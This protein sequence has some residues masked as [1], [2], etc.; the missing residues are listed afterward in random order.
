M[1]MF[2]SRRHALVS[3]AATG[4]PVGCGRHEGDAT[5][6]MMR[7]NSHLAAPIRISSSIRSGWR[8][9]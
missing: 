4:L 8:K 6:I 2:L 3:F 9:K 7:K 1:S 5:L